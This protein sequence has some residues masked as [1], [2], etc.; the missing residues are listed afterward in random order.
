MPRSAEQNWT[1][2]AIGALQ[3]GGYRAGGA[4]SAVVEVL[5]EEGG[6][7]S[8][9]EVSDRMRAS[10]RRAGTASIYRALNVLTELGVLHGV[11]MAGAPVRYELVL[12]GGDHHHH[13][14]CE[15]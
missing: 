15:R 4:R 13:A 3:K 1:E 12:P 2:H 5:G 9:E 14:V 6:C 11:S 7:L 8:A 10:G